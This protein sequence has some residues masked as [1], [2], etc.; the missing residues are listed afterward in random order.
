MALDEQMAVAA[1]DG[2]QLLQQL[3]EDIFA[4]HRGLR[5]CHVASLQTLARAFKGATSVKQMLVQASCPYRIDNGMAGD[6]SEPCPE[7]G[8]ASEA[9]D[10]RIS[11]TE[12]LLGQVLAVHLAVGFIGQ[13]GL[14]EP[15]QRLP[16]LVIERFPHLTIAST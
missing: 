6:A 14:D 8:L 2:L 11:T 9:A 16:V 10:A 1:K 3:P 12:Y 5:V 15:A 13:A 7:A 4:H